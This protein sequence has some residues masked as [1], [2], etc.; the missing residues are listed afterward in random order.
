[1]G[2]LI[3]GSERQPP[4]VARGFCWSGGDKRRFD[5]AGSRRGALR[6]RFARFVSFGTMGIGT[7][8]W[9]HADCITAGS[10]CCRGDRDG[11]GK[12]WPVERRQAWA[13]VF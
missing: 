7:S 13:R 5:P 6:L 12:H 8:R 4:T 2:G 11:G 1:M 3:V 9:K 10:R